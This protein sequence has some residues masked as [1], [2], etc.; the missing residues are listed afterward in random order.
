MKRYPKY[1]DSGVS[2]LGEIPYEWV[3]RRARFLCSIGTGSADTEDKED[4]AAVPFYV[5]SQT[6]ECISKPTHSGEAVLTAGDGAGVGKVYHHHRRGP[7]AAHQRVYVMQDFSGVTARYFYYAFSGMFAKVALDGGAKSTVD[8]LRRPML[9]NFFVAL[10]GLSEQERIT[11][12]LDSA[13]STIDTAISSQERLIELLKE[14]RSVIITLA[15]TKGLD[16]KAKMKDSGV[17]WLGQVPV[18]WDIKRCKHFL[19]ERNLRSI[20]GSEVLLSVSEYFGVKPRAEAIDEGDV[21]VRAKTLVDYKVCRAGDLVMN[22]MLAWKRAYGVTKYDGIVSPA[23]AVFKFISNQMVPEYL[24]Y[25]LRT[26]IYADEFK[27]NSSGVID[28]R[29]RLYPEDFFRIPFLI[30]P[31]GEQKAIVQQLDDAINQMDSAMLS[32]GRMI[33]LLKERRSAIITQAVTGQIDVR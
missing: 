4:E 9:T 21:L 5:R 8:S 22:I 3:V 25:L 14:R 11:D 31:I 18:H 28:S 12:Y 26:D 15:V 17:P 1:K 6:V 2:W 23:Y 19:R 27:R 29:L 24:H 16:P 32:Q 20:D 30:P 10:P 13:I 7:F 33:E